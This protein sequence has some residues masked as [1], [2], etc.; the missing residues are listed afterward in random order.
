MAN[1]FP[2]DNLFRAIN[3]ADALAT[4]GRTL[5]G[6][7]AVF[8]S[9][10]EINDA[11]EG[12]FIERFSPGAF[13]DTLKS[14]GDQIKVLFEH[15]NDYAAGNKPLGTV[16]SLREDRIG[17]AYEVDLFDDASYVRDLMPGL[18]AGA[19]GASFRFRVTDE[20][21]D[22]SGE[23]PSRTI[24]GADVYEFGPVTF[25]AYPDA[26]AGVRSM[27]GEFVDRLIHDPLFLA[28]FTERTSLKAVESII[29][30]V[31]STTH[32]PEPVI[33]AASADGEERNTKDA[34]ARRHAA[35]KRS[36]AGFLASL[37][38]GDQP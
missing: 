35:Y 13:A 16:R 37:A 6:H 28:R 27:T 22:D 12:R 3:T 15:G 5:Y 7:F 29:G 25:P 4:D 9:P 30:G 11:Y 8:N 10:M 20:T 23:L 14:R 36:V 26:T 18:R 32:M 2:R 31:P 33:P 38:P 21:W 24:T 19:Y 17:V 34:D 1:E